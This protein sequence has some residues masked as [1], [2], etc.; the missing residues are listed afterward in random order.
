LCRFHVVI[1][2][3]R[4]D[5]TGFV[6]AEESVMIEIHLYATDEWL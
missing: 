2:V 3:K 1:F 6:L 4:P 5:A